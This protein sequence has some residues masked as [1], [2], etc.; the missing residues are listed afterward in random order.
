MITFFWYVVW[1]C[2]WMCRELRVGGGVGSG[3]FGGFGCGCTNWCVWFWGLHALYFQIT[4]LNV[5]FMHSFGVELR[6]ALHT[7][8]KHFKIKPYFYKWQCNPVLSICKNGK[9]QRSNAIVFAGIY[10]TT[11]DASRRRVCLWIAIKHQCGSIAVYSLRDEDTLENLILF[12]CVWTKNQ[13][14]SN[15]ER[16]LL[17]FPQ[18]LCDGALRCGRSLISSYWYKVLLECFAQCFPFQIHMIR[19]Y[20]LFLPNLPRTSNSFLFFISTICHCD[21]VLFLSHCRTNK[22]HYESE[23]LLSTIWNIVIAQ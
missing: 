15:G 1:L 5:L 17:N 19:A 3:G 16:V 21:F 18:N 7:M 9:H 4:V 2:M 13:T 22:I 12:F 6:C 11:L 10:H 14:G 23:E 8:Y 20:T